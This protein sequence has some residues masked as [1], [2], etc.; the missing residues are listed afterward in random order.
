MPQLVMW[1]L[2]YSGQFKKDLKLMVKRGGDVGLM[3][4]AL[5]FLA[6]D[7][8]VPQSYNPHILHGKWDGVWECHISPDWLL[9]YDINESISIIRLVRTGTHADMFKK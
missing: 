3:R 2:E 6:E 8:Q 5:N 9:L 4:T 7:G 1:N